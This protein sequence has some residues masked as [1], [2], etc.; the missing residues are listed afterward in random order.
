LTTT[1]TVAVL[2]S[3]QQPAMAESYHRS[4][5]WHNDIRHFQR[6]DLHRWRGGR[7]SHGWHNGYQGWWWV[8]A[9]TWYFYPAP[10]YPYPNPYVPPVVVQQSPPPAMTPEPSSAAAPDAQYW[11]YCEPA[12]TYYPYVATCPSGWK[13]VPAASPDAPPQ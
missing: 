5:G 12:N 9:G 10:V 3:A 6:Y 1:F 13:K 11:Y 8:V 2:L 7:W 4:P